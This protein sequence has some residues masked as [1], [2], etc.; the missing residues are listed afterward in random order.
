MTLM[1]RSCV[2][3]ALALML[4]LAA[5]G[6]LAPIGA[7]AAAPYT[8][9]DADCTSAN[10]STLVANL[11]SALANGQSI[12]YTGASACTV[13]LQGQGLS[14]G[15]GANITIDGGVGLTIDGQGGSFDIIDVND[16]GDQPS[17]LT[18]DHVTLQ[19]GA[20]GIMETAGTGTVSLTG[21]TI[22][23]MS[24]SGV[25]TYGVNAYT[26]T[27]TGS[28]ISGIANTGT[29]AAYAASGYS[30]TA[31]SS[32]IHDISGESVAVGVFA[33]NSVAV[34]NS[35]ITG[36]TNTGSF[37]VISLGPGPAT[38]TSSTITNIG[39][40]GQPNSG[41]GVIDAG[42]MMTVTASILAGNGTNCGGSIDDGGY[43]LATD[44]SCG[45]AQG[46]TSQAVAVSDLNLQPLANNGGPTQTIALGPGSVAID[47]IPLNGQG[48]CVAG[49]RID[50][51]GI[52]RPLGPGCDVG[53]YETAN[54]VSSLPGS[55]TS[56]RQGFFALIRIEAL[57]PDGQNISSRSLKV[58]SVELDG[59]NGQKIAFVHPFQF[60]RFGRDSGYQLSIN[61][62]NL[63][64]GT[65]T[66]VVR[67]G[68]DPTLYATKFEVR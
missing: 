67:I 7:Q 6:L 16:L 34:I 28:T 5:V 58:S 17:T 36:I 27:L 66:L 15:A 30:V 54:L 1:R 25:I 32:T 14:V 19:N 13:M 38:V 8:F 39:M 22:Q 41:L 11:Q 45:F 20:N 55:T 26:V 29:G 49:T 44:T 24:S 53:A 23:N 21:S 33:L 46:S 61:T 42:G 40:A 65:W 56:V 18:L 4:V 37:G 48:Q 68:S 2:N 31:D 43:N 60:G 62:R 59:P 57:S 35:T 10:M 52:N 51:R 63:S 3:V 50:Q 64:T 12:E 9:S 47:L